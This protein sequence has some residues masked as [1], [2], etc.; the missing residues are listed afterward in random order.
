MSILEMFSDECKRF[1]KIIMVDGKISVYAFDS[2]RLFEIFREEATR[3][4]G[5]WN[6]NGV[7]SCLEITK[8]EYC[9]ALKN[10]GGKYG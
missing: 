4:M 2:Y 6:E 9:E 3:H 5:L 8:T 1:A 10:T 7:I